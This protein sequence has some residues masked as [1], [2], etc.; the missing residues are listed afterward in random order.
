MA[1]YYPLI[2]KAISSLPNSTPQTRLAI[3]DRARSAL[4]RQ[5]RSMQPPAPEIDITRETTALNDAIARL[6][7]ELAPKVAET[8]S[9]Q[10]SFET[11]RAGKRA[12]PEWTPKKLSAASGSP[13]TDIAA[14]PD[15]N[16]PDDSEPE[17]RSSTTSRI[18]PPKPHVQSEPAP[19]ILRP[20]SDAARP[21]APTSVPAR[22]S[23]ARPWILGG[24]ALLVVAGVASAAIWLKANS[25]DKVLKPKVEPTA[26]NEVKSPGKAEIRIGGAAPPP[27]VTTIV[28][29]KPN[30]V[31][32][33]P[34]ALVPPKDPIPK[35]PIPKDLASKDSA[36]KD[37]A[38]KD[39]A[40]TPSTQPAPA[41]STTPSPSIP[42]ALRAALLVAAPDEAAKFKTYVGTV[43]WSSLTKNSGAGSISI[44]HADVSVPDALLKFGFNLQKND[45]ASFPASHMIDVKFSPDST[46]PI[47][48]VKEVRL[49][50]M[51]QEDAAVGEAL[52]GGVVPITAS[53]YLIGLSRIDRDLARNM[54]LLTGRNWIDVSFTLAD[55]REAKITFEKG[56]PGDQILKEALK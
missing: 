13:T 22:K 31:A 19:D 16:V 34:P 40:T 44:M 51:R 52:R 14:K 28:P 6:E 30:A 27:P 43:V 36:P 33:A 10:S 4:V 56:V 21:N 48:A 54:E 20:A 2:A 49:P 5:L 11:E 8:S 55:G 42:I 53:A 3:Y 46:S 9:S 38:A 24:A 12:I 26:A 39:P 29:A 32:V 47:T 23:N 25:D 1:E 7:S 18:L 17:F 41:A 37:S 35:D 50:E 45:D 15:D